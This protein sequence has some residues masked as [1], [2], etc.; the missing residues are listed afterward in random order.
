MVAS[1]TSSGRASPA[2]P[3]VL[4]TCEV[5]LQLERTKGELKV[6][7]TRAQKLRRINVF[8]SKNDVYVSI[9]VDHSSVQRTKTIEGAG[10]SCSFDDETLTFTADKVKNIL[11]KC[12]GVLPCMTLA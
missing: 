11:V 2:T 6:T 9:Q 1:Q 5:R 8:G 12:P 4:Q 3:L 10:D 7:V